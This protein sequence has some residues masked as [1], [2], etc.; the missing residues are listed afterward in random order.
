[1]GVA[2]TAICG[3]MITAFCGEDVREISVDTSAARSLT[4]SS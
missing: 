4:Q 1:M 3:A 2:V